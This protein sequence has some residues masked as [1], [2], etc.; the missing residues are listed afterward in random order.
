MLRRCS[1]TLNP[2]PR[3]FPGR[4]SK[5]PSIN[6]I[7]FEYS[8]RSFFLFSPPPLNFLI[9]KLVALPFLFPSHLPVF[10]QLC[11]SREQSF[12]QRV[13]RTAFSLERPDLFN[14]ADLLKGYRRISEQRGQPS[15]EN[16]FEGE[17][18]HSREWYKFLVL[19]RCFVGR[20]LEER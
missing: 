19:G 2:V 15:K 3:P 17:G 12:I 10:R 13:S 20:H 5:Q 18:S 16:P 4:H 11:A 9:K 7:V 6:Y 1:S 8:R 14:I